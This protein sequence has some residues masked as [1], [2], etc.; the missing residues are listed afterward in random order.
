MPLL[1]FF[2]QEHLLAVSLQYKRCEI[3]A[4]IQK[5]F[6]GCFFP[7]EARV[8]HDP[9]GLEVLTKFDDFL[10]VNLVFQVG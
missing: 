10:V 3:P 2:R 6:C 5:L 9:L 4:Q 1:R 8:Y 7:F